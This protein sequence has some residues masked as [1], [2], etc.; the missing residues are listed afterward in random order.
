MHHVASRANAD[1]LLFR[2]SA[3]RLQFFDELKIVIRKY[4]WR[5]SAYCLMGSHFHL[6]VYTVEPTLSAGMARLC[7]SY[8]RWL[9]WKYEGAGHVFGR[10]FMSQHITADAHLMEAHRYIALNPVRAEQCETPAGWRW[11]SYRALAGLERAPDFL[12][13]HAV[14]DLFGS[15]RAYRD[16]VLDERLGSDPYRGQTPD[17]PSAPIHS[18]NSGSIRR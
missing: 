4:E 14:H 10:R 3:D 1:K 8:A 17:S 16:F 12:D 18:A 11:G 5:C 2:E 15:A 13:V 7:A 9:N 6:I